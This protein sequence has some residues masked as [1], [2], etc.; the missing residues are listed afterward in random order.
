MFAL[1]DRVKAHCKTCSFY[2][3]K[4]RMKVCNK[5]NYYHKSCFTKDDFI[6]L[7]IFS[8]LLILMGIFLHDLKTL[9]GI[10]MLFSVLIFTK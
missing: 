5:C 6:L 3:L 7:S 1:H 2:L 10:P 8:I 4:D 9:L